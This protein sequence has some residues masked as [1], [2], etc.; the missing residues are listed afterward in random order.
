MINALELIRP[1]PDCSSGALQTFHFTEDLLTSADVFRDRSSPESQALASFANAYAPPAAFG[2]NTSVHPIYCNASMNYA[3]SEPLDPAMRRRQRRTVRARLGAAR[4]QQDQSVGGRAV[5]FCGRLRGEQTAVGP[6]TERTVTWQRSCR[7]RRRCPL[8][9]PPSPDPPPPPP[10]P[11]YIV[12]AG[13]PSPP[14]PPPP[15][16]PR[17][18]RTR[19]STCRGPRRPT[20][21]TAPA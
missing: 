17:H 13:T 14:P 6:T 21:R 16:R 4:E 8:A 7:R 11:Q 5:H 15:P 20:A 12:V 2:M 10:P 3:G 9:M 18:R 19:T 1:H